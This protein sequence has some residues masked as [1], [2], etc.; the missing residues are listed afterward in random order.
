MWSEREKSWKP[1][2]PTEIAS[3]FQ[4]AP[5]PWWV[6]GGYAIEHF[7]GRQFRNHA[8]I[9]ILVLRGDSTALRHH[10]FHWEC[11]VA[12]PSGRFRFWRVGEAL[13]GN[14]HDIWGRQNQCSPWAFQVMIDE[15]DG[16]EW[17]SR[18]CPLVR[19]LIQQLG[20]PNDQGTLFLVPEVQL[21]YKAKSPRRKD[22][23]DLEASWPLLAAAQ[24]TW[25]IQA[26][27]RAYGPESIWT[28]RLRMLRSRSPGS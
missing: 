11:W 24:R 5:F 27:D 19:K 28:E 3:V 6:A 23:L 7:V 9:D 22:D 16:L 15:N 2:S 1:L 10:L 21:F 13:P 4:D 17:R 26:I 25:L 12:D 8:D 20:V 18:R 14:I